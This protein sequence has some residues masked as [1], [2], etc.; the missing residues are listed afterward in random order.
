MLSV[1]TFRLEI[2]TGPD[3]DSAAML[4]FFTADGIAAAIGQARRLLAAAEGPDDR[5]G[6]LYVRDGELAT[7]LTTLH[8]GA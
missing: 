8:L 3:P 1:D 4:A 7:W 5:F 6:E 2:V